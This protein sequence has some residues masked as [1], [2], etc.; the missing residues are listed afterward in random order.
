MK[1]YI[2]GLFVILTASIA[3]GQTSVGFSENENIQPLIEYRL[4]DW[5]YTNIFLDFDFFGTSMTTGP[6]QTSMNVDFR[7]HF[8][9]DLESEQRIGRFSFRPDVSYDYEKNPEFSNPTRETTRLRYSLELS[10]YQYISGDIFFAFDGRSYGNSYYYNYTE[11]HNT[12]SVQSSPIFGVGW[13]RIRNVTPMLRALRFEERYNIV[14]SGANFSSANRQ[15]MARMFARER[16]YNAIHDRSRKYFWDDF[17][18]EMP[19]LQS[20]L[21]PYDYFYLNE[22]FQENLGNRYEG[23]DIRFLLEYT[24]RQRK[25]SNS[26]VHTDPS[27]GISLRYRL[28]KNLNLANQIEVRAMLHYQSWLKR[29]SLIKDLF[30]TNDFDFHAVFGHLWVFSD[31]F[32]LN[33]TLAGMFPLVDSEIGYYQPDFQLSNIGP[34]DWWLTQEGFR[35]GTVLS[36]FIEDQIIVNTNLAYNSAKVSNATNAYWSFSLTISYY[37]FRNR[38]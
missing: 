38:Y 16:G 35:V 21:S 5:G 33:T 31:R 17:Y 22:V 3:V 23:W 10:W 24:N 4:P 37:I 34:A 28:F 2:L 27:G 18:Q 36:Y 32:L 30:K 20:G 15:T 29:N 8:V 12:W 11:D 6:K 9:R 25:S 14:N 1:N 7:P 19:S 13:G 26:S